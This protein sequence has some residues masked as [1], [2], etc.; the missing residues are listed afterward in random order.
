MLQSKSYHDCHC[1]CKTHID[2]GGQ[3][4]DTSAVSFRIIPR[5]KL[6]D[7]GPMPRRTADKSCGVPKWIC[8]RLQEILR[9]KFQGVPIN[10]PW[11]LGTS[12]STPPENGFFD[13]A[14]LE[15]TSWYHV[16]WSLVSSEI[17]LC[18]Q[19]FSCQNVCENVGSCLHQDSFPRQK[20]PIA[21][22]CA[23]MCCD[24]TYMSTVCVRT[25]DAKSLIKIIAQ[26]VTGRLM[27]CLRMV[28]S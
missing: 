18:F 10:V 21:L 16:W 7:V 25:C 20:L 23:V 3:Q 27:L 13:L 28:L 11:V 17:C 5:V 12:I 2:S 24:I 14:V 9:P 19:Y 15:P 6:L 26:D 8:S 1:H 22:T 4:G